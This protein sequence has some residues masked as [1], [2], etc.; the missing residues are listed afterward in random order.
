MNVRS[1]TLFLSLSFLPLT[2]LTTARFSQGEE[3]ASTP[4]T[5]QPCQAWLTFPDVFERGGNPPPQPVFY[6]GVVSGMGTLPPQDVTDFLK[7]LGCR[8]EDGDVALLSSAKNES[9]LLFVRASPETLDLVDTIQEDMGSG[10]AKHVESDFTLRRVAPDGTSQDLVRRTLLGRSGQRTSFKR[11]Q[12]ETEVESELVEAYLGEDGVTVEFSADIKFHLPGTNLTLSSHVILTGKPG[13]TT[14]LYSGRDALPGHRLEL[15]VSAK[16]ARLPVWD[17]RGGE[18]K[19]YLTVLAAEINTSLRSLE[20]DPA[21]REKKSDI[22]FVAN[23]EE[24]LTGARAGGDSSPAM[25]KATF[26]LP[27]SGALTVMNV[28]GPLKTA[29]VPLQPDDQAWYSPEKGWLYIYANS[30][31]RGMAASLTAPGGLAE[32]VRQVSVRVDSRTD[33][34]NGQN[35]PA[36]SP[37][38]LM[39]RSGQRSRAELT[40]HPGTKEIVEVEATLGVMGNVADLNLSFSL[41]AGKET[42]EFAVQALT[43]TDGTPSV[44]LVSGTTGE[45]GGSRHHFSVSSLTKYGPSRDLLLDSKRRARLLA[46]LETALQNRR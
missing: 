6:P 37:R 13:E 29:G 28:S 32:P 41:P 14:L 10:P 40:R 45:M 22:F 31:V 24:I 11:L 18:A 35:G 20:A 27:S 3:A 15:L 1:F 42:W 44:P 33:A 4:R 43:T 26:T 12:G 19:D 17:Q 2:L 5:K 30:R 21:G 46:E 25:E 8:F 36:D 16:D 7:A 39:V 38:A 23:R 9:A 34:S